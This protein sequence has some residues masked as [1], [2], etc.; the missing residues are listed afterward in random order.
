MHGLVL[1]REKKKKKVHNIFSK[2]TCLQK[3][4]NKNL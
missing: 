3:K 1:E 2:S 4:S